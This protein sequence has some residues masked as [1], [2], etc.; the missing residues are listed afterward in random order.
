[1]HSVRVA[2]INRKY[3]FLQGIQVLGRVVRREAR[4]VYEKIQ[5][6]GPD[7]IKF[8]SVSVC[9]YVPIRCAYRQR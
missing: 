3:I 5:L 9:G 2:G 7:V 1:M 4:C 6:K 8:G